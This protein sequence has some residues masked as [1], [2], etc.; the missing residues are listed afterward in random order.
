MKDPDLK[1]KAWLQFRLQASNGFVALPNRLVDSKPFAALTT[2][3][4]VKAL[5]WFWGMVEYPKGKRKKGAEPVIGRIDKI[6]NNGEL[7]FTYQ[8]AE[9]RG[10]KQV[11]FRRALKE[12][13]RLGFIDISRQGHGVKGEYTKYSI[14]TR[15]QAY[16]TS[17]W[18][19]IPYPKSFK[20][21]FTSD[22]Y[23]EKRK[24]ESGKNSVQKRTLPAFKNERYEVDESPHNVQERT[25]KTPL[26]DGFQRSK[27][28]VSISDM[29][30]KTPKGDKKKI[31]APE[32]K[33]QSIAAQNRRDDAQPP[34]PRI[35]LK[36]TDLRKQVADILDRNMPEGYIRNVPAV[37]SELWD[38][39][40]GRH[41]PEK[42][43]KF[44][45]RFFSFMPITATTTIVTNL[46]NLI[47]YTNRPKIHP[48]AIPTWPD[49][50]K[51]H[52]LCDRLLLDSLERFGD[53]DQPHP[54]MATARRLTDAINRMTLYKT[55]EVTN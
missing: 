54:E 52:D 17:E 18:Q 2:G 20:E 13:H 45:A 47:G 10:I 19:E 33:V 50:G 44:I 41:D 22:K 23:I 12:L 24:K 26:F 6:E 42:A 14:S 27:T 8:E 29:P 31:L 25:L 55:S 51:V 5:V 53:D 46:F 32:S 3:A 7:S 39:A 15:W 1:K 40:K 16:D 21:G 30:Q 34:I 43:W 35:K 4:S 9:W 38:V 11:R 37:T 48:A 36:L 49:Q 28:N